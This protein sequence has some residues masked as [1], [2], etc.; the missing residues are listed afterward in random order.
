MESSNGW[1]EKTHNFG[2]VKEKEEVIYTFEYVG[3]KAY[4]Y[5]TSSCG[6]TTGV[7]DNG[8]ILVKYKTGVIPAHIKE[9]QNYMDTTKKVFVYFKDGHVDELR[10]VGKIT[11]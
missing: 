2:E 10:L 6:C 7:W 11:V 4:S 8:K 5:H 3:N 9:K 1:K